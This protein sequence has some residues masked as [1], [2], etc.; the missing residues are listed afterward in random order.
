M[1]IEI[2]VRTIAQAAALSAVIG[3]CI[4]VQPVR[5]AQALRSDTYVLPVFP[6]Q[7]APPRLELAPL[8]STPVPANPFAGAAIPE[9]ASSAMSKIWRGLQPSLHAEAR[10]FELCRADGALCPPAAAS[11]LAIVDAARLQTGRAR[12][13]YINRAV[14][15]AIRPVSDLAQY[16]ARDI[17]T[18]P[19]TTFAS[20]RGDCEDYAIAK[21]V[22]L[23]EA[24]VAAAD[25]RLM[26]V[27]DKRIGE[28]HAVV[29]AR[30]DGEWLILDNRRMAML[31]EAQAVNLA[32]LAALGDEADMPERVS[33]TP[34][35]SRGGMT[36][37][38][39]AGD[40]FARNFLK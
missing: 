12:L 23:R 2:S 40:V 13:G 8:A 22:A 30:L 15:L 3:L 17:W 37:L 16:G 26:I 28:D 33:A 21:F 29:A 25:R 32:P 1:R 10:V 5:P 31:S 34:V 20:G 18:T 39:R 9:R 38:V 35:F 24:G 11:F 27:H 6:S 7:P 36:E 14:N 19:L 4:A